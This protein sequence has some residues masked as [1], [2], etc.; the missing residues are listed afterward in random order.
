V[1][2]ALTVED[3]AYCESCADEGQQ[4]IEG[5]PGVLLWIKWSKGFLGSRR[6]HFSAA[7]ICCDLPL[8]ATRDTWD[9]TDR[10][11]RDITA[12]LYRQSEYRWSYRKALRRAECT[13]VKW[14]SLCWGIKRPCWMRYQYVWTNGSNQPPRLRYC[15][16]RT[17]EIIKNLKSVDRFVLWCNSQSVSQ[18][19]ETVEKRETVA[20]PLFRKFLFPPKLFFGTFYILSGIGLQKEC[21]SKAGGSEE[22]AASVK[23]LSGSEIAR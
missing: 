11:Y 23:I 18:G 1:K 12:Q 3:Y 16:N 2:E 17:D 13:K 15:G 14:W 9:L 22:R 4:E 8:N 6:R 21:R 20:N 5:H 7:L 10:T 19:M